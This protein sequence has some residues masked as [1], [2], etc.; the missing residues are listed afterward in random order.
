MSPFA[1]AT[2]SVRAT[3]A[4]VRVSQADAGR[5]APM[6]SSRIARMVE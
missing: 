2:V 3:L 4:L 6:M 5:P 1:A